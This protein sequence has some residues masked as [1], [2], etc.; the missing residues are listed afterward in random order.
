[1]SRGG[2][3]AE[4]TIAGVVVEVEDWRC[5]VRAP[6]HEEDTVAAIASPSTIAPA[7]PALAAPESDP[8]AAL[9]PGRHHL[10]LRCAAEVEPIQLDKRGTSV[11]A[12]FRGHWYAVSPA[13]AL[14][15]RL[16]QPRG[17]DLVS[18]EVT[19]SIRCQ[20]G[21]IEVEGLESICET[22]ECRRW[23]GRARLGATPAAR[24][25]LQRVVVSGTAR[26][27]FLDGASVTQL[28]SV[29]EVVGEGTQRCYLTL[30]PALTTNRGRLTVP[31][32]PDGT[33]SFRA[34]DGPSFRLEGALG[35]QSLQLVIEIAGSI[36][37][38]RK[39]LSGRF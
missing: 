7:T 21:V 9:P 15:L 39:E 34:H 20:Y 22:G 12:R 31:V 35:P 14:R 33:F 6:H 25:G 2:S 37:W 16:L 1:M 13:G 26:H 3:N 11:A 18:V 32:R 5:P 27:S 23:L 8:L 24:S 29:V 19:A 36:G 4:E 17:D 38:T 30:P 28:S 10:V